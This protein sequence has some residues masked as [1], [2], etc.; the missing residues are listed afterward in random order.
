MRHRTNRRN[1][2]RVVIVGLVATLLSVFASPVAHA[3]GVGHAASPNAATCSQSYLPLPDPSCTPGALNPDVTQS[4]IGS[5]ICVSG[6]TATVRPP[7]SY[8]NPLKVQQIVQ[9][10]YADTST[11]DYEEDHFIPLELGGAPRDPQ[12]LWPEPRNA[13]TGETASS[14]D[15]VETKLKNLVCDGT[16]TLTAAQ[17]ALV[18]DWRTAVSVVSASPASTAG[19]PRPDH[20]VVV[21]M[22]NHSYSDIIGSSDAPY[23]N[24]LAAEGAN[25]TQSFAV[26]HPSEPNYLALF[27]GSTHGLT[28][29][30]CPH[31]YTSDNLGKELIGAGD[32][33]AGYS[34]SMPSNGYTGCTS[35]S[36][37][38]KHNPWVNFTSSVPTADNLTFA[39]LPSQYASLPTVSFVVPN[40]NDDMHDGTVAAGD[41][42]LQQHLAGYATWASTHN[43]LLVV[44][45]DEDDNSAG[46]QIPTIFVGQHVKPGNY[47]ETI[48][49]YD[50]LRTIEDAYALPYAGSAAS[51]T[52]I[53]DAWN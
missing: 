6:W 48:N 5:T 42:W 34:E 14:K 2:E 19:V 47:A 18:A 21:M 20:L 28:S 43:S 33:F 15:G 37:A 44:T 22:E 16:A 50:V 12:N 24:S 23:L 27:S 46:N 7:T 13:P 9:Y 45:W 10:G 30:S 17:N 11:A 3:G 41:S 25:F 38:R 49:H 53:T 39:A 8:T 29:D 31:S 32:S 4:T 35:G 26:T 36:Y 51:A 1:R 52:P 40:L